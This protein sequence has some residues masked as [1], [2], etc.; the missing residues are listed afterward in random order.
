[1]VPAR[2]KAMP[3]VG[4]SYH[5]NNSSSSS[6]SSWSSS[7]TTSTA[8]ATDSSFQKNVD[9][10]TEMI[11]L[12]ISNKQMKDIVKKVRSMKESG[13]SCHSLINF[14]IKKYYQKKSKFNGVY[15]RNNLP[16]KKMGICN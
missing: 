13:L 11:Q 2:N 5:K 3:F 6:S 1:M 4:Q 15:S 16:K 7:T 10:S 9:D 8:S 14:E 12:I